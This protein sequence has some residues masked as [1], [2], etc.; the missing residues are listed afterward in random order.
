GIGTTGPSE[1]LHVVGNLR[2][3]GSTD[4]TLGNGAGATNCTSDIRLKENI[5]PIDSALDKITQITGVEFD[6]NDLALVPGKHSMGVIA[7]EVQKVF[8]TA[9][10]EN[11]SGYLAVDYAVLVSPLI[12][13]TKELNNKCDASA[14]QA[15][16][17]IAS[18]RTENSEIKDKSLRLE[19]DNTKIKA[20][21]IEIKRE[22]AKIKAWLCSK[23]RSAP[24]CK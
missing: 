13:A 2:V 18:L 21:N 1:K 24:F 6:W 4:C 9:V 15:K 5:T 12:Q 8:P 17:E 11:A 16:V 19:A 14:A 7:Q 10:V 23:D 20:Q 22:N 3:Q